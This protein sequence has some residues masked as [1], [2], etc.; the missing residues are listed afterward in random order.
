MLLIPVKL[1]TRVN[2]QVHKQVRCGWKKWYHSLVVR[3]KHKLIFFSSHTWHFETKIVTV[4]YSY[5]FLVCY[6]F[7]FNKM[8]FF[9]HS[10]SCHILESDFH[11]HD[12]TPNITNLKGESF[13]LWV[14][15]EISVFVTKIYCFSAWKNKTTKLPNLMVEEKKEKS[16][17][18]FP[19]KET[20]LITLCPPTMC[21]ITTCTPT[22]HLI[23]LCP[24]TMPYY[25]RLTT[26]QLV[27]YFHVHHFQKE[28]HHCLAS[29]FD[30]DV[31]C[32]EGDTILKARVWWSIT[33]ENSHFGVKL[34]I[35]DCYVFIWADN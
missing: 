19:F 2:Y 28:Y 8:A 14:I 32:E 1:R 22:M 5:I 15:S 11:H 3:A 12:K 6:S 21:L 7:L 24:S 13:L 23:T 30:S 20:S 27:M 29:Y 4:G 35:P 34:R 33:L 26:M 18:I 17:C 16:Y 25:W 9:K 31:D 10:L